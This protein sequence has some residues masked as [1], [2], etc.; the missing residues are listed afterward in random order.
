MSE[1]KAT[2][3]MWMRVMR[4][5]LCNALVFAAFS[6]LW[7]AEYHVSNSDK[8][9]HI[10]VPWLWLACFFI[11]SFCTLRVRMLQSVLISFV[12]ALV[13][14]GILLLFVHIV[15]APMFDPMW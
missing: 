10:V 14:A 8:I 1:V 3:T 2:K 7:V 4:F 9:D 12:S 11:A 13:F 6:A 5:A 15:L